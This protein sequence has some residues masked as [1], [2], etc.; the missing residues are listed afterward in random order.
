M[1]AIDNL[2]SAAQGIMMGNQQAEQSMLSQLQAMVS[3]LNATTYAT[4]ALTSFQELQAENDIDSAMERFLNMGITPQS[5][6]DLAKGSIKIADYK[7][8]SRMRGKEAELISSEASAA[9]GKA[10][11]PSAQKKGKTAAAE[12]S[13]GVPELLALGSAQTAKGRVTPLSSPE[14]I[15]T[16]T[17]AQIEE[18]LAAQQFI[19]NRRRA[20]SEEQLKAGI[21]DEEFEAGIASLT[22]DIQD[23]L[24]NARLAQQTNIAAEE[25]P[26]TMANQLAKAKLAEMVQKNPSANSLPAGFGPFDDALAN[27]FV[28]EKD[29]ELIASTKVIIAQLLTEGKTGQA[30]GLALRI[31]RKDA[32]NNEEKSMI[33]R[34]ELVAAAD[35][36]KTKLTT[37]YAAGGK[38]GKA[39]GLGEQFYKAFGTTGNEYFADITAEITAVVQTFRQALTGAGFTEAEAKSYTD[40]FPSLSTEEA[41]NFIK[42]NALQNVA[43]S[44]IGLFYRNTLGDVFYNAYLLEKFP[45][46]VTKVTKIDLRSRRDKKLR[47]S[48]IT[49][50]S[51]T[52][53][54]QATEELGPPVPTSPSDIERAREL[55]R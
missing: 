31:A 17:P 39:E 33:G 53:P 40:Q 22:P 25:F 44:N 51:S 7:A 48:G 28:G 24:R 42:I 20:I 37:F 26:G 2:A 6:D 10:G 8:L 11:V 54:N 15:E 1:A 46:D 45:I 55:F 16:Q 32:N 34:G 3:G 36:I 4:Q 52:Q 9:T 41:L 30:I 5:I 12:I 27:V 19:E 23:H 43:L 18:Q 13:L 38:T 21:S 29:E 47:D 14:E 50:P 49:V 35:R